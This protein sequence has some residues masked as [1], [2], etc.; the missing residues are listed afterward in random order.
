MARHLG[1]IPGVDPETRKAADELAAFCAPKTARKKSAGVSE[2]SFVAALDE[3]EA[4]LN[5]GRWEE[6]EPKHFVALY[7]DLHFKVYGVEDVGLGKKERVYATS[8]ARNMLEKD[9]GGIRG[10][11]ADFIAWIWSRERGKEAWARTANVT[12][13]RLTWRAVFARAALTDY[14]V[15]KARKKAGS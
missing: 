9:F 8:M 10:D 5:G 15:D 6:A 12:R 13:G 1:G 14:R 3:A 11:M 7:A 4:M 2:R